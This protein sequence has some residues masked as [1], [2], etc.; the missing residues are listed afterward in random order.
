MPVIGIHGGCLDLD[1][2]F[3]VFGSGLFYIFDLKYIRWPIFCGDYSF[4]EAPPN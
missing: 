4:H 2:D 3:I 1:Q